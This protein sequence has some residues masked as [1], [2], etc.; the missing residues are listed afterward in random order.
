MYGNVPSTGLLPT[1]NVASLAAGLPHF[2]THHMR[3]W[4]RDVFI[5]LKGLFMVTGL[6]D[7]AK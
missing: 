3:S 6:H 5:S 1:K 2:T 7:I 4:G